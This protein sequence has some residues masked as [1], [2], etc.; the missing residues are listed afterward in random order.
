MSKAVTI[1]KIQDLVSDPDKAFK[2]DQ[3]KVFLNQ[4]P[5]T[6]WVLKNK[7]ANDSDYMPIDKVEYLLDVIFQSWKVEV[8]DYKILFNAISVSVRLHYLDTV[9]GEWRYHDG[10][11]AKE[12]QT[13]KDT[14]SLKPD[15]SNVNRGAVEMALPIAKTMAIKDAADHIGKI[16]GR[17][18]NRKNAIE[19]TPIH[20]KQQSEIERARLL[21]DDSTTLEGLQDIWNKIGDDLKAELSDVFDNKFNELNK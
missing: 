17:D 2:N 4:A 12:L 14:G 21:I 15:G 3:L 18:L 6:K 9:S 10:V 1:P 8:L 20:K 19:Y 16:F 11:G 7:L 5:P 13:K